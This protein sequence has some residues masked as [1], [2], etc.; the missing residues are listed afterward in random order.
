MSDQ[1]PAAG[2]E[3]TRALEL[4]RTLVDQAEDSIE[5]DDA[6]QVYVQMATIREAARYLKRRGR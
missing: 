4:L 5:A 1:P 2:K 3:T 6:A